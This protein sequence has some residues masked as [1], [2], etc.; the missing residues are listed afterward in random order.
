MI[1]LLLKNNSASTLQNQPATNTIA[2]DTSY[3][4]NFIRNL[5]MSSDGTR[6]VS[7][8]EDY[9]NAGGVDILYYNGTSWVIEKQILNPNAVNGYAGDYGSCVA[10]SGDAVNLYI[11]HPGF[12]TNSSGRVVFHSRTGTTWTLRQNITE[13]TGS[14][15][16]NRFG[17]SVKSSRDSNFIVIGTPG[18]T[19][20]KGAVYVYQRV[21]AN[22]VS[23]KTVLKASDEVAGNYFGE[24]VAI[25]DDATRVAVSSPGNACV[26]VFSGYSTSFTQ[27]AKL[28]VPGLTAAGSICISGNGQ[29]IL[30]GVHNSNSNKGKALLFKR[31]GT[32]WSLVEEILEPTQANNSYFGIQVL[33]SSDGSKALIT[34]SNSSNPTASKGYIY[35]VSVSGL[36]SPV[37]NLGMLNWDGYVA[38]MPSQAYY[39]ADASSDFNTVAMGFFAG[40][41]VSNSGVMFIG[42]YKNVSM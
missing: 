22:S 9:Y 29:F 20:G 5:G 24:K 31:V 18:K 34:N 17:A 35:N 4:S 28:S 6:I 23:Y 7:G 42:V 8:R 10:L 40:V 30:V 2:I 14:V 19:S 13:P 37:K 25:T 36:G 12:T 15:A 41:S 33:L 3:E 16:N 39:N 21:T 27:E 38:N 32:T 1:E 11:G 26:Y